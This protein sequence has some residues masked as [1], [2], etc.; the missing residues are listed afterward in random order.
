MKEELVIRRMG[1]PG[2]ENIIVMSFHNLY[3]NKENPRND[4]LLLPSVQ[5]SSSGIEYED[6]F[7]SKSQV[8]TFLIMIHIDLLKELLNPKENKNNFLQGILS[9]SQPFLYE[10][11]ISPEM[12][13][14][15]DEILTKKIPADLQDF[16]YRIKA[17]Q[18]IYLLFTELTKREHLTGYPLNID[19]VKIIYSIRDKIIADL[20][21]NPNLAELAR[22]NGMSESKIKRL[23]KQIF[24]NS[25][26]NY[27]Q[28]LRMDQAAYLIK[29]RNLTVSEAGYQIG[30]SNLSHFARIF[31]R[32]KGVKPKKYAK[33]F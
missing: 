33:I 32:Y 4:R 7:P 23:F 16:F 22:L 3:R 5:V 9:G 26:Y 21:I 12:Q 28:L 6:F 13:D 15:A 1:N 2:D 25:I 30:F 10:E 14:I 11:I 19:D 18:L 17:E 29:E 8:N 20:S 24:G 31:E 27:Y